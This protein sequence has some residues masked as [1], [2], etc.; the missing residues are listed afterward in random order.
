MNFFANKSLLLVRLG[1]FASNVFVLCFFYEKH[2][3]DFWKWREKNLARSLPDM[4]KGAEQIVYDNQC[5][6]PYY[7]LPNRF[8]RAGEL[9]IA[10]EEARVA[11]GEII[12]AS[13]VSNSI[14]L[15]EGGGVWTGG[16]EGETQLVLVPPATF[17]GSQVVYS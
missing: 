12:T 13:G 8:R 10:Q 15:T 5:N 17:D 9:G 16:G 4:G 14:A 11:Q 1:I 2:I 3:R 7:L 6:M